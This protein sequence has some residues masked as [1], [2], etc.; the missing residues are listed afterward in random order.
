MR[1]GI[2]KN[3]T[4][5][6]IPI[7]NPNTAFSAVHATFFLSAYVDWNTSTWDA[8]SSGFPDTRELSMVAPPTARLYERTSEVFWV[9]VV[10]R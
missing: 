8:R 6:L 2:E 10:V 9:G 4:Y 5:S 7:Q 3:R 1:A